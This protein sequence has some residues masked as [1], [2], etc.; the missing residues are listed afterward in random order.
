MW[1]G[2]T[3]ELDC[4]VRMYSLLVSKHTIF[5]DESFLTKI[6]LVRTGRMFCL[7]VLLETI[8]EREY[9]I[10]IMALVLSSG[11]RISR[12]QDGSQ[13]LQRFRR[14]LFHLH[15]DTLIYIEAC[16]QFPR[17]SSFCN[18]LHFGF[19][20]WGWCLNLLE[21]E[22][23][24]FWAVSEYQFKLNPNFFHVVCPENIWLKNECTKR[25]INLI[26]S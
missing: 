13:V 17:W 23:A 18:F 19:L 7:D 6:T 3:L 20:L 4:F 2:F 26:C 1:A 24:S 22:V 15:I 25:L 8:F 9:F 11:F 21:R 14:T 5:I 10:T 12:G 16:R